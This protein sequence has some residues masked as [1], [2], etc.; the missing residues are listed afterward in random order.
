MAPGS[1]FSATS[2][3]AARSCASSLP[4]ADPSGCIGEVQGLA[5]QGLSWSPDGRSLAVV[6]RSSPGE[7]PRDL[8]AGRP[9]RREEATRPA[10][11][12]R[13]HPAG[14][15][16]RRSDR[17]LQP[18]ARPAVVLSC[19]PCPR[20]GASRECSCQPASRGVDW[21]GFPAG[22]RSSSPR[23]PSHATEVNP[24]HRRREEPVASL[25]RV[26]ADG[27]QAR[28]LAGSENAVDV[29]VSADGRRLVYSQG[30]MDW[31]I[32]RLD[33]R[34][35]PATEE[36]QTR[37]TASTEDRR[38]STVFPRWR[39]SG[40]HLGSE[41]PARDLGRRRARQAPS[42]PDLSRRAGSVGAPRWSPDGKTIAFDF[43]AKGGNNVD[44][45]VISASGGPPRR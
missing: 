31:D 26:P 40:V 39:A 10:F 7:S 24:G 33:L 25:W 6:D 14:L 17:R 32:W 22:R 4:P 2:Q 28:P 21:P 15:L 41:R 9:E 13:R 30:T 23:C 37:F 34:R 44:I 36:A 8:R 19:M 27:G 45:Y 18:D 35:G 11:L 42:P 5:D 43:A 1:R 20:L 38:Q 16:A 12:H 3:G 29:A